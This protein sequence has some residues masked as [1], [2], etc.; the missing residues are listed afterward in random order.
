MLILKTIG[1][2]AGRY[3]ATGVARYIKHI[4][5]DVLQVEEGS[6]YPAL[7]GLAIKGWVSGVVSI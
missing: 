2:N 7:Q 6:I 5:G 3:T 1:R 4:P